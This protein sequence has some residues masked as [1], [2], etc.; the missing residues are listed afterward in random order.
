M[1]K[2]KSTIKKITFD[3]DKSNAHLTSMLTSLN[4]NSLEKLLFQITPQNKKE[5]QVPI[6][7]IIQLIGIKTFK[8][9]FSEHEKRFKNMAELLNFDSVNQLFSKLS[10]L[11]RASDHN[12]EGSKFHQLCDGKFPTLVLIRSNDKIFGAYSTAAFSWDYKIEPAPG[13]FLFSLD[14]QTKLAIIKNQKNKFSEK[15]YVQSFNH[16]RNEEHSLFDEKIYVHDRYKFDNGP[17]FGQD[18]QI[19]TTFTNENKDKKTSGF[20]RLGNNFSLPLVPIGLNS[21]NYS[22]IYLAGSKEF[23]VDEYEVFQLS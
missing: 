17:F 14:K 10:L 22:E 8:T 7:K 19:Y 6:E 2:L 16:L 15:N 1:N 23:E 12:F 4:T 13:S 9:I 20:S 11:Y 3:I 21:S 18:L 5:N